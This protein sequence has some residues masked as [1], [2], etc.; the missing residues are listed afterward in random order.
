[1]GFAGVVADVLI[2]LGLGP[3]VASE[4]LA[5]DL[6]LM[7]GLLD[8]VPYIQPAV[9]QLAQGVAAGFQRGQLPLPVRWQRVRSLVAGF[10]VRGF[11]QCIAH[12]KDA[13]LRLPERA[14]GYIEGCIGE[15]LVA[16]GTVQFGFRGGLVHHTS[17]FKLR[18]QQSLSI[19]WIRISGASFAKA[20]VWLSHCW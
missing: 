6:I 16:P 8:A 11:I 9:T 10:A 3:D 13:H 19:C 1:M 20:G 2:Q 17:L 12:R 14:L 18:F 7:K 5:S 15:F 4:V